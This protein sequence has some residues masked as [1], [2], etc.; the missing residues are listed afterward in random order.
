MPAILKGYFDRV[1]VTGVAFTLSGRGGAIRPAL[2]NIKQFWVVTTLGSP[3]WLA[4]LL[5]RNPV[6][7]VLLG[8]LSR[9]CGRGVRTRYLAMYNIDAAPRARTAAFLSRVERAFAAF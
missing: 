1:W 5:L 8:G 6:R 2:T 7:A 4:T 3:W 9:L